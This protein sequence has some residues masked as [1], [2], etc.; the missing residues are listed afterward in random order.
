MPKKE[1]NCACVVCQVERSLLDSLSTQIARTHFQA[2]TANHPILNH[3]DS[4]ADVIA[5]LHEHERIDAD[6]HGT[7]NGILHALVDGL[8]ETT[9][10]EIGQQ[11]LLVAYTPAIHKVCREVCRLFPGL[12]PEDIA[13]QASVF[14]LENAKAPSMAEQNGHLPVALVKYFRRRLFRWAIQETQQSQ[15]LQGL[16][17]HDPEPMAYDNFE[18]NVVVEQL[19][20]KAQRLGVLSQTETDLV[21]KFHCEGCQPEELRE[22]DGGRSAIAVYRRIQRAVYRLRR[23]AGRYGTRPLPTIQNNESKNTS[24]HAVECSGEMSIR[25]SERDFSRELAN[26]PRLDT[27]ISQIAA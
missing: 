2:L 4:P 22:E 25:N 21:C 1:S 6:N 15:R 23:I 16:S 5:R 9:T 20:A 19:L 7:W 18:N 10:Q 13:Q 27:D 3:F 8:E 24:N 12:P 17:P 11:L 26:V 14:F